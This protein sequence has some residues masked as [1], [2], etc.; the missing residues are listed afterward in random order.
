[1]ERLTMMIDYHNQHPTKRKNN[2]QRLSNDHI[3]INTVDAVLRCSQ[4]I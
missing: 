1:M 2:Q 3:K 4:F